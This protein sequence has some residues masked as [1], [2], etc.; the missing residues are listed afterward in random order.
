MNLVIWVGTVLGSAL[1]SSIHMRR[2]LQR[3]RNHIEY[4]YDIL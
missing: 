1:E 4:R 2:N 3:I